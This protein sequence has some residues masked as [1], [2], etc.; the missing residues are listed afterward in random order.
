MCDLIPILNSGLGLNRLY[1]AVRMFSLWFDCHMLGK[2]L[3][4]VPVKL[5]SRLAHSCV[6]V[7]VA[8]AE[9]MPVLWK[10]VFHGEKKSSSESPT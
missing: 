8:G 10:I 1:L 6:T 7:I 9:T 3:S 4:I 2:F 5:C